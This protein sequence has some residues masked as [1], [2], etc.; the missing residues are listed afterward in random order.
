[1]TFAPAA[2]LKQRTAAVARLIADLKA[3]TRPI[4]LGPWRSELGFEA[5]YW[6]PF[7]RQ[8]AAQV[9]HF[10]KRAAIITRGGLAPLYAPV[11]SQG[12]D[13]Y[14]LR[15]VTEVRRENLHD[16][17]VG[18]LQKQMAPTAWDEDVVADAA[19]ALGLGALYHTVHP[20]WMYWSCD[21]FWSEDA[22]LKYL[23]RLCDFTPIAK[24]DLG[25]ALPPKYVAVKF[26]GRATFPY[27]DPTVAEFVTRIVS[28]VSQQ[29]DVVLLTSSGEHDDHADIVTSGPRIH[30]LPVTEKPEDNLWLQASVL[31]HATAFVGTYGGVSQLALR[32]G[33]P[34]VSFWSQWG[35]TAHAHLSL[36]SWLSKATQ[37]PFLAGSID[38]AFLW[39]QVVGGVTVQ[40]PAVAA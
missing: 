30:A 20:A 19:D 13:L 12:I 28:T 21:P 27:P 35:G 14:A 36:S 33:V 22:G 11:A 8:L 40:R 25:V 37:T 16:Q 15:S 2:T 5:L 17:M 32:M 9:P 18:G 6:L 7:L 23:S 38:D 4:V 39:A 1:M 31:A 10:D 3:D 34:S 24:P 26:Y 29:T